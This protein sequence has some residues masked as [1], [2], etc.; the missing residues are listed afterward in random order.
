MSMLVEPDPSM[1]KTATAL[2]REGWKRCTRRSPCPICSRT[3]YCSL[4]PDGTAVIC[5]KVES[6]YPTK[7]GAWLH[8]LCE[9]PHGPRHHHLALVPPRRFDLEEL[10]RRLAANVTGDRLKA[11]ADKL[12]VDPLALKALGIGW[13]GRIWSFPMTNAKGEIVGLRYRN[14]RGEKWSERGGHEGVFR[15]LGAEL[16]DGLLMMP[17]GPTSSAALMTLGF[18]VVGRPNCSG[19][20]YYCC[21][22]ARGRDVV[23]V[24]DRDEGGHGQRGAEALAQQLVRCARSVRIITPPVKDVRDYLRAGASRNDIDA[25]VESAPA[26]HLTV[27][28]RHG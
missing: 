4:T 21:E 25:L 10:T 2:P 26:R 28:H 8:P 14:W 16:A 17:E 5:T 22:L 9:R 3:K 18:E 1:P 24:A 19:A 6:K 27:R 13:T 20:V 7:N 11:F 12:G 15:R 23:V